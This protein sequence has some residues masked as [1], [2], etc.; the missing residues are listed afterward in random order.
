MTVAASVVKELRERTGAGMMECKKALQEV[1]G[2]I[3]AAIE[4]MRKSGQAKAAKKSGRIAAE[5]LIAIKPSVDAKTMA[6]VEVNCET[7]FVAKD[8]NFRTF[9]E[10]VANS[11]VYTSCNSVEELLVHPLSAETTV[12]AA[13]EG[14]IMKLGENMRIRRF[15]RLVANNGRLFSYRH[16]TRIGVV[17]EVEGGDDSLGKDL[18][19]H[20]AASNPMCIEPHQVPAE[21][22]A[23]EREIFMAQAEMEANKEGSGKPAHVIAM[24]K[25]KKVEGR[26]RKFLSEVTLLGQMFVKDQKTSVEKLLQQHQAK[27]HQFRRLEVGEGLEKKKEDFAAQVAAQAKLA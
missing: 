5:G 2:D 15:E 18:A 10:A 11:I 23:K 9:V 20:I 14:L 4:L 7:D 1:N 19:M 17:V 13:L 25:E 21:A 27:V 26:I 6:M 12:Q 3:E 24:I 16:G 22:V 8:E